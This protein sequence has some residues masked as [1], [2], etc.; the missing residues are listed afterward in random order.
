MGR[1]GLLAA[2]AAITVLCATAALAQSDMGEDGGPGGARPWGMQHSEMR[3][4]AV[5]KDMCV[6]RFARSAGHLAYLQAKLQL[7]AEQKPLWDKW[8]EATA[9]G[10]NAMREACLAAVPAVD[11]EPTALEREARMEN[12]LS[13]KLETLKAARPALEALYQSLTPEQR[14]AFDRR[15]RMLSR[16]PWSHTSWRHPRSPDG[17][18]GGAAAPL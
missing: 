8:A 13:A 12:L 11:K 1:K 14:S 16:S 15:A 4:P 5:V 17:V 7:K 10:A 18:T 6:E 3:D 9:S 2:A